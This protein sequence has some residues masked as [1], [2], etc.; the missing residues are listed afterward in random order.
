[1]VS[2]V[3]QSNTEAAVQPAQAPARL[4]RFQAALESVRAEY[5]FPGATAAFV[6][7]DGTSGVVATGVEGHQ[8][9]RPL[10]SQ[11]RMM[12]GSTGKT[13]AA[14]AALRLA[15]LGKLDLDAPIGRY[16]GDRPWFGKWPD[17]ARVTPRMLLAHRS[18]IADHVNLPAYLSASM[19]RFQ[20]NPDQFVPVDECIAIALSAPAE[21]AP[22]EGYAYSDTGYLIL[23]QIIEAASGQRYYDFVTNEFLKP[24]G[25]T[26]TTPS[27]TRLIA[28]LSQGEPDWG[29]APLPPFSLAAPGVLLFSPGAEWT[30]GGFAT[31]A[32]DLARWAHALYGGNVLPPHFRD[33]MMAFPASGGTGIGSRYGLGVQITLSEQGAPEVLG[34]SGYYPGYR[35]DLAY[36]PGQKVAIAFQIN[37]EKGVRSQKAIDAIRARLLASIAVTGPT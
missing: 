23:G 33:Q 22:G 8:E 20:A 24:H 32:L 30:G 14:A 16:V 31:N 11:A 34:H 37:T 18:G 10:S 9:P 27:D 15:A 26:L 36:F 5:G 3:T 19:M 1:V 4:A 12:S 25:L 29:G 28:G 2:A 13:F 6:L 17:A 7:A 21:F 35:S